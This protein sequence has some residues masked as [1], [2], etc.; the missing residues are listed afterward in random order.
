MSCC[1]Y[2]FPHF[3]D[4]FSFHIVLDSDVILDNNDYEFKATGS[5]LTF[6]GYL[7]VYKDYEDTKDKILPPFE[8]YNS[9]VLVSKDITKEQHFT[10]PL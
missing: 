6:D 5:I 7:K 8:E 3:S 10:K 1:S 4:F 2:Y 9:K